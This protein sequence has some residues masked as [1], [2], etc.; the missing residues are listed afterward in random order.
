MTDQ[1]EPA[2]G[3]HKLTPEV[4][5]AALGKLRQI[6]VDYHKKDNFDAAYISYRS[7]L[8][9]QPDDARVWSNIG[10]IL[11][12]R[13]ELRIAVS[14]QRR[15]HALAP[16]NPIIL[17]NLCNALFDADEPD[18]ALAAAER[19]LRL[20]PENVD[21]LVMK[22][23]Y[24]RALNRHQQ[25]LAA[26]EAGLADAP[27]HPKLNIQRSLVWLATG[28]YRDGFRDQRYRWELGEIGKPPLREPEWTGEPL[29]GKCILVMPE[30]G[31]GD[32]LLMARFLSRLGSLGASV[33][34]ACKPALMRI[35]KDL[36]GVAATHEIGAAK[37]AFDFY[38]NMMDLPILLDVTAETIPEPVRLV[39]PDDSRQQAAGILS[40]YRD[41]FRVGVVWSGS[42]TYKGNRRRSLEPNLFLELA[43]IP[44][45]QL[46]S[47]YKGPLLAD[48]EKSSEAMIIVNAG[49]ED[50]DFADTAALIES[51]DLVITVDTAVAHLA[52]ALRR[53]VWNLLDYSPYWIY[54][55]A[56]ETT[57]WYPTMKL[58]RQ[59]LPGDWPELMTR[60]ATDLRELVG[61]GGSE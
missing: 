59:R 12:R 13:G 48:F 56:G 6:A 24:L 32:T 5:K 3:W 15:A 52:G 26:A 36:D 29:N 27:E 34:L 11:R 19:G 58:Y 45:V 41:R 21:F 49:A 1:I 7:Y 23:T 42:V 40:P 18:E 53:P 33:L 55:T 16:E 35:L 44:N 9:Q 37:P 61:E 51:L 28:N 47:L 57:S 25:A 20:E 17:R 46:F 43:D 50:R 60:V 30:Q 22:I 14:C 4:R 10:T 38:V 2:G 8:V 54:G 39:V 31:F